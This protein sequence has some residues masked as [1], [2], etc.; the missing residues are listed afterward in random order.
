VSPRGD[1]NGREER[2]QSGPG[3]RPPTPTVID[4]D[5]GVDDAV[6][7]VLAANSPELDV[8]ALTTVA[9]NAPVPEC[10]RNV[11]L[12]AD[13]LWGEGRPKV[14]EGAP[15]PLAREL[16]TAPEVHGRDG[17]GGEL[18]TLP[19][20]MMAA[21]GIPAPGLIARER[22]ATTCSPA[23]GEHDGSAAARAGAPRTGPF[24]GRQRKGDAPAGGGRRRQPLLV[25][26]GPLT[27]LALA[28]RADPEALS[29]FGRIVIM[30]GALEVRGNTGPVAEFNFYVDPEAADTVLSSGLDITVVPL[31]ATTRVALKRERLESLS[32]WKE[33]LEASRAPGA[34]ARGEGGLAAIFAR[35]LDHYIRY[36]RAESGLDAGYMHDPVALAA[37]FAPGLVGTRE[38]PLGVVTSDVDRG[39]SVEIDDG[40]P[41]VMV[42][43][44]A[45]AAAIL[46]LIE[47][48]VLIPLF[49]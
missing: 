14:A 10:S 8:R 40:R 1:P 33:S 34:L 2:R 28:L 36:Q 32:R 9:G 15:A 7:V 42:A 25:A 6:A 44:N 27:N 11:L 45:D 47:E 4:T 31:D 29:G 24:G 38:T 12:L 17:L 48:R 23:S 39:R 35:A 26:T 41:P 3:H 16:L 18:G 21:L 19:S 20:P 43:I 46:S 13:R 5:T 22:G 49:G 37:A 30:G